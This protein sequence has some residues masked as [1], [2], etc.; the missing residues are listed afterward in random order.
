MMSKRRIK[1]AQWGLQFNSSPLTSLNP[2]YSVNQG[3]NFDNALQFGQKQQTLLSPEVQQR[4]DQLG[5]DF[6]KQWFNMGLNFSTS[7]DPTTRQ[8][9]QQIV[10]D[11]IDKPLFSNVSQNLNTYDTSHLTDSNFDLQSS[12]DAVSK[13]I[14][15]IPGKVGEIGSSI[16][17]AAGTIKN[18]WSNLDEISKLKNAGVEGLGKAKAG[19]IMAIAGAVSDV[20][21]GFLPEKTEYAGERGGITQTMDT[22]YDGISDAA[23]A[24]GPVGMIVGGAMKGGKL[25][26][27]VMNSIGGGTDGMCVCAGTK[28]FTSSGKIVNIE[29][30]QKEDGI[31]GWNEKTKQI[32]PQVVHDFIEPRQKECLEI[33]LKN[34]YTLR[35]SIDHPILSDNNQKAKSQYINGKRIALR[36]WKFRR[37]DE[38]QVGDF[39]GLA[40]NIDYWGSN[41]EKLAY[42][43]GML[44]GDGSYSKGS[45]CRIFSADPDTWNYLESN[46]LGVLNHCDDSRPEKY[47]KEVRTYRIID[48]MSLLQK[49]GIAYQVGQNKTLPKNIGSFTKD[50]VCKLLAGLFDTDGNISVNR[51][52]QQYSITLYQ[53]NKSLLEEVRIQ[54]H[55]LG[56]FSTI[57]TRKAAKY[58][59]GGNIVN[60]NESY[61][62]DIHD[63][64]SAITFY[65]LIPLNIS[66]KRDNLAQIY[67]MLKDKKQQEHNDISGAKQVK[68][69]SITPI[70]LQTVYNLQADCDHTY[71]ANCIITHNT[72]T[73]AILGSSFLNLTPIGLINGFGGQKAETITKNDL[74]FEQV[75]ASY[76]GT[77]RAVDDA[78]KKSGKKYGLF[79]SGARKEANKEILEARRQQNIM[80]DIAD[81]TTDRFDIRNSMAAINGNRRRFYMQGGYD[82]SAIRVGRH[83]MIIQDLQ[84][85][86]RI[87]SSL[88]YQKGGKTTDPFQE[89][90]QTLPENQ[91]DDS[92][93]RVR[94]YWEFNGRPKDFDE[95]ISKGMFTQYKDVWHAKSVAE[96]PK[97]GEIEYMKSS[98]HPTR[99]MESDWYE[100]GLVYD[101]D[102]NGNIISTKLS[103]GVDG[104]DDW[105]NFT[106]N[107]ELQKTEPYWKYVKRKGTD[108]PQSFKE[109]G[110]LIKPD[111]LTEVDINSIPFEF[112][113]S[114]INEVRL[115][116]VLQEFR[117][118]GKFNL[119]PE[120]AL[121]AR[122]HNMDVEGITKKGIPVVSET[123]GGELEQQAEIEREEIIF[124]L[125]VTKKIEELAKDGS[126]EAAI[127]AGK[128]LVQEILYNTIDNT[129][130]LI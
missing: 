27:G 22:V 100:K 33:V 118:G 53:S 70:G 23:M 122:K 58:K 117:E 96:N 18:A 80:G 40:N 72:T 113:E 25:L 15:N 111:L 10:Q 69:V 123:E 126:D 4:W 26:G 44:I 112:K 79:S 19:N 88:K 68:I 83:G 55:K 34:G 16:S 13:V 64:A 93:F 39:V 85:A 54:L 60:S 50:S 94:D 8:W 114:V 14:N 109:G 119:I 3:P 90:L 75:G 74:A 5:K 127:E 52:K 59:L 2:A 98:N 128:L 99:Y 63:I 32:V 66:Y 106:K 87:T 84:R 46:N 76:T 42:L 104:Y 43:V 57:G 102:E 71:L 108:Q 65:N 29:N 116:S 7:S 49:L 61:R 9:G 97:T 20:A 103:P 31:I 95:A 120:G 28:V 1:K 81:Y 115:D 78:L 92:N 38:L 121:H 24:F 48:G 41:D 45:S 35:C 21:S 36:P 51:E 17:K 82:Q 12:I 110:N 6:N 89:Y 86:K 67:E 73:D 37:A 11:N 130:S 125:E 62:L 124:R 91:R 107:Y 105:L 129:N 101:E 77:G 56:I 30:L 47:T